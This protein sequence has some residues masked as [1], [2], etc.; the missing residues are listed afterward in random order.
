MNINRSKHFRERNILRNIEAG[1]AERVFEEADG[2]YLDT[3]TQMRIAI[4]HLEYKGKMR[5]VCLVYTQEANK[6]VTFITIHPLKE[7]QKENRI[8]TGRW[9][10]L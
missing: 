2:N 5:D 1:I 3:V 4:K 10:P 8:I 9:N 6:E 7:S